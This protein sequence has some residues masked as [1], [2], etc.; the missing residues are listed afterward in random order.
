MIRLNVAGVIRRDNHILLVEFTDASGRHYNLP[1]GGVEEGETLAAAVRR[2]VR[3]ETGVEVDVGPL[4][5]VWEYV[6]AQAQYR[7]GTQHRVGLIYDCTLRPGSDPALDYRHDPHQTGLCWKL[8][9]E[10]PL[11]ETVAF[12]G[13]QLLAILRRESTP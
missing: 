2:E 8:L 13:E 4:L 6:P 12:F 10:L 11:L 1:G 9:V 5:L 3:E 7:Y